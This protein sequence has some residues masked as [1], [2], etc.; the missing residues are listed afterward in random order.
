MGIVR[1]IQSVLSARAVC[2]PLTVSVYCLDVQTLLVCG[3]RGSR[4][5]PMTTTL[6][7]ESSPS[8]RASKRAHNAV[9]DLVLLA[10]PHLCHRTSH[11]FT[12]WHVNLEFGPYRSSLLQISSEHAD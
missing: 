11:H 8:M 5:Q 2:R 4:L 7:L 10:A 6:P 1:F 9:V 12:P 3:V